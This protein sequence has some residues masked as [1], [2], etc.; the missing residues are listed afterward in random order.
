MKK[1]YVI[2]LLLGI[3]GGDRVKAA[4]PEKDSKSPSE[5]LLVKFDENKD[6][7]LKGEEVPR[8]T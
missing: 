2:L 5:K 8:V 6:G 3:I 7:F 4:D 1:I